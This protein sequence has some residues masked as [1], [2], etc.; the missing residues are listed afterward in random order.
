MKKRMCEG[1]TSFKGKWIKTEELDYYTLEEAF[2]QV[3][4]GR[5]ATLCGG[6]DNH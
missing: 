2:Q 5:S 3:R 1:F 4:S 6:V